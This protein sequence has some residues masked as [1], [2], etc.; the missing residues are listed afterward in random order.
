MPDFQRVTVC[1]T[2]QR[3]LFHGSAPQPMNKA[4]VMNDSAITDVDAVMRVQ[5]APTDEM[6]REWRLF[7]GNK[8]R[9]LRSEAF[10]S[11]ARMPI[12]PIHAQERYFCVCVTAIARWCCA[13]PMDQSRPCAQHR[14]RRLEKVCPGV[15]G[16][17]VDITPR[18]TSL[19]SRCTGSAHSQLQGAGCCQSEITDLYECAGASKVETMRSVIFP[20]PRWWGY[21]RSS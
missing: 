14:S 12:P 1:E 9:V 7:R 10:V 17:V 21:L 16:F 5:A 4:G 19:V 11:V 18:S 8:A 13:I 2:F 20:C 15:D 3:Y 6:R